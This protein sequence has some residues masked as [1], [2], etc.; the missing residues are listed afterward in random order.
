MPAVILFGSSKKGDFGDG[1]NVLCSLAFLSCAFAL[2]DDNRNVSELETI[3][4]A[5][6]FYGNNEI[7]KLYEFLSKQKECKNAEVLWRFARA[8]RDYS[9]LSTTPKHLKKAIIYEGFKAAEEAVHLDENIFACHKVI[10]FKAF[11]FLFYCSTKFY[12]IHAL[13][14]S[15]IHWICVVTHSLFNNDCYDG[16]EYHDC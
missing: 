10:M 3:R 11:A 2:A 5:D 6:Q 7:I 4:T 13:I 15:F 12:L 9:Q 8:A 16:D 14:S 1:R